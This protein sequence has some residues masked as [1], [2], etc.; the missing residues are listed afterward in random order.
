MKPTCHPHATRA[1][2]AA[3]HTPASARHTH[4]TA[5]ATAP[6]PRLVF[7]AV[8]LWFA[9]GA[10]ALRASLYGPARELPASAEWTALA[11]ASEGLA[12]ITLK[13][14]DCP[15]YYYSF[16][17]GSSFFGQQSGQLTTV[18]VCS[19]GVVRFDRPSIVPPTCPLSALETGIFIYGADLNPAAPHASVRAGVVAS[20]PAPYDGESTGPC[21]V[22]VYRNVSLSSA[23]TAVNANQRQPPQIAGAALYPAGHVVLFYMGP[24]VVAESTNAA[25]AERSEQ[26]QP[27]IV[28]LAGVEARGPAAQL[29]ACNNRSSIGRDVVLQYRYLGS[30]QPSAQQCAHDWQCG[31]CGRC[32][33][34]LCSI[35]NTGACA[36]FS[37]VKCWEPRVQSCACVRKP[38]CCT[39]Q[40]DGNCTANCISCSGNLCAASQSEADSSSVAAP[41]TSSGG[42]GSGSASS[43]QQASSG[44]TAT[45]GYDDTCTATC[46]LCSVDNKCL[47]CR[48]GFDGPARGCRSC[49]AGFAGG[50]CS[51][52][53]LTGAKYA[54]YPL[55]TSCANETLVYPLCVHALVSSASADDGPGRNSTS[56][57][58]S[59]TTN[60]ASA[61]CLE[62]IGHEICSSCAE[63]WGSPLTGCNECAPYFEPRGACNTCVLTGANLA[64][65]P[66]C[67][68]CAS[69]Y[70]H[71]PDCTPRTSSDSEYRSAQ[72]GGPN[73]RTARAVNTA[74]V[75]A[76]VC[77]SFALIMTVVA[78]T[79]LFFAFR[80]RRQRMERAVEMVVARQFSAAAE[81]EMAE[82]GSGEQHLAVPSVPQAP[83]LNPHKYEQGSNN[84]STNSSG[85][86]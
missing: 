46:V 61:G 80:W 40:W 34:S 86:V 53:N 13:D 43:R 19:N 63:G 51:A 71:Y 26:S 69:G 50:D 48:L 15:R 3:H 58:S 8:L 12:L 33:N 74:V 24:D 47:S 76:V 17:R 59:R 62:C 25:A 85:S 54:Q 39:S 65:Y 81:E 37:S 7:C 20:C 4:H 21:V 1:T 55:C 68:S 57:Q 73:S 6:S 10:C 22:F 18:Y 28:G 64:A 11:A 56:N 82:S 66:R 44:S 42:N 70:V 23:A 9:R 72:D 31:L 45:G 30:P 75:A 14:N 78:S 52:C 16:D 67:G 36:G 29:H 79:A 38:I 77:G 41:A 84:S 83:P 2:T 27:V 5:T 32:S 35:D 60:C 49:A